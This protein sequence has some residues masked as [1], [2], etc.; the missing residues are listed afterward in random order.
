MKPS[1]AKRGRVASRGAEVVPDLGEQSRQLVVGRE[2]REPA[3][4]EA[5][6]PLEHRRVAPAEPDGDRPTGPRV[7][8]GPVDAVPLPAE[9][10]DLL[11]PE[12][13]HQLDL[14]GLAAAPI[15]EVFVECFVFHR[16]PARAH[17]ET[18]TPARE[19]VDLGSLL[20]HQRGLALGEDQHARHQLDAARDA[21]EVA[22]QHERFVERRVL[23]VGPGP[24]ALAVRVGAEHVVEHEQVAVA[25]R[26]DGLGEVLDDRRVTADFGLG[27][28]DTDVHEWLLLLRDPTGFLRVA[29][30]Q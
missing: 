8:A 24:A 23:V 18:Q 21:R 30:A 29:V 11:G 22:E 27:E 25:E 2:Q 10:D 16:V 13:P 6:H 12:P 5:G 20:R 17:A 14:L 4:A 19:D 9:V 26:L 7:D 15:V 28:D 1:S 3:V